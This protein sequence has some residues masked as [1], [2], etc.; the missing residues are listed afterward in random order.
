MTSIPLI[1]KKMEYKEENT[2]KETEY[3]QALI[4]DVEIILRYY[5]YHRLSR[6]NLNSF[7]KIEFL[8]MALLLSGQLQALSI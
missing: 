4:K 5:F 8:H 1:S 7:T 6:L 2:G 3:S